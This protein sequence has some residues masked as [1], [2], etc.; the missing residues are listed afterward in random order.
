MRFGG[1]SGGWRLGPQCPSSVLPSSRIRDFEDSPAISRVIEIHVV[2][3]LLVLGEGVSE[4]RRGWHCRYTSTV[5][6][7]QWGVGVENVALKWYERLGVSS[8]LKRF[9]KDAIGTERAN[10]AYAPSLRLSPCMVRD[11][12]SQ[13]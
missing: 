6:A 2:V 3:V 8:S 11:P 7:S 13:L 5:G 9:L 4:G 10:D 1:G 12:C